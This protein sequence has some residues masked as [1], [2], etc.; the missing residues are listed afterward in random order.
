MLTCFACNTWKWTCTNS[1]CYQEKFGTKMKAFCSYASNNGEQSHLLLLALILVRV[2]I[3]YIASIAHTPLL[4][5][6]NDYLFKYQCC[7]HRVNL[8]CQ[9][10]PK[11]FGEFSH[12]Y[13]FVFIICFYVVDGRIKTIGCGT[14]I[15]VCVCKWLHYVCCWFSSG[16]SQTQNMILPKRLHEKFCKFCF[17]TVSTLTTIGYARNKP[18][19]KI[20]MHIC[21]S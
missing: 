5:N 10:L 1:Q 19:Q 16:R 15:G 18:Y 14:Q 6:E 17:K 21:C 9:H 11:G 3:K 20:M 4:S 2:N 13:L 7:L 12:Q 8:F